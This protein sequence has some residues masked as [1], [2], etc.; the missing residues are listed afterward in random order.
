[1]GDFVLFIYTILPD[2]V[3]TIAQLCDTI[4][5]MIFSTTKDGLVPRCH[6]RQGAAD[7]QGWSSAAV[8]RTAR[9]VKGVVM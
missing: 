7:D 9:N 5:A 6:G 4:N 3:N 1:M 2:Y 8:S